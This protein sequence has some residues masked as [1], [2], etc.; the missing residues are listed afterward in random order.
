MKYAHKFAKGNKS[1]V[2]AFC[3]HLNASFLS[4]KDNV[5]LYARSKDTAQ[6]IIINRAGRMSNMK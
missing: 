1:N 6:L 2:Y 4:T 3:L 5:L